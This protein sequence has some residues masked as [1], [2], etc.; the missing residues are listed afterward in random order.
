MD[1]RHFLA[2]G[3]AVGA[4]A[5][6]ESGPGSIQALHAQNNAR[7]ERLVSLGAKPD[8]V[9]ID[10]NRTAVIVVDAE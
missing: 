4:I 3:V 9:Q 10:L 6:L 2:N 8:P 7:P 5:C 1:R